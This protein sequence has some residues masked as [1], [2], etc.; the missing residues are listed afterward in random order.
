MV[1][2]TPFSHVRP[3]HLPT[4]TITTGGL[5][6]GHHV[7]DAKRI[8]VDDV[9]VILGC[10]GCFTFPEG[11]SNSKKRQQVAQIVPPLAVARI[12]VAMHNA[13]GQVISIIQLDE[14]MFETTWSPGILMKI[15]VP[16]GTK[17]LRARA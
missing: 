10:E 11:I 12:A 4:L 14:D 3:A 2:V 5:R 7:S 6:V 17:L 16:V 1:V 9:M 13:S 15:C 8:T